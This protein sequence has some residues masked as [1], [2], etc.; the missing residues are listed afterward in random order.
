[1]SLPT[2]AKVAE[3]LSAFL[4]ANCVLGPFTEQICPESFT[5]GPAVVGKL[6]ALAK[7]VDPLFVASARGLG[8][9]PRCCHP[10][11]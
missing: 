1:M 8:L 11:W 4:E 9:L 5:A 7:S 2:Y 10:C 6:A 3:E